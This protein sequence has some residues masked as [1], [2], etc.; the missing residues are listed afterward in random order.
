M[1]RKINAFLGLALIILLLIHGV[2][3]AF[4]LIGIIPGGNQIRA[5]ITKAM[6]VCFILHGLIGI[7]LTIDTLKTNKKNGALYLKDNKVFW[8]R[9]I[10]GLAMILFVIDHIVLFQGKQGEVFRLTLFGRAR[11]IT[12][13]L[14]VLTVCVHVVSNIRPLMVAFG[15]DRFRKI[16][17][18]I[19]FVLSI[20][21]FFCAVSFIFY[22]MRW[23][24]LWKM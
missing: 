23:N 24:V 12:S 16:L 14:L 8:I 2:S 4:V 3:G 1:I 5:Y 7:K 22:Y 10:S 21:M 6:M 13:L 17:I 18:D 15:S 9:R 19:L 20:V 11:L